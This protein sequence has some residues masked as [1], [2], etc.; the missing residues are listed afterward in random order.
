MRG[1]VKITRGRLLSELVLVGRVFSKKNSRQLGI[2]YMPG[3]GGKK[4][5]VPTSWPSK[6]YL[7]ALPVFVGQIG[8]QRAIE[9]KFYLPL[10]VEAC[11]YD[12]SETWLK[13][14][15]EGESLPPEPK[16]VDIDNRS[17]SLFDVM[18]AANH[19]VDDVIIMRLNIEK[20]PGLKLPGHD[21]F[22]AVVKVYEATGLEKI[23]GN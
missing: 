21:E 4:R 18:K 22:G 12:W 6:A 10:Y 7:A 14:F 19:I 15:L 9:D 20:Y 5:P 8:E 23:Y 17:N 1:S 3:R 13:R 2:K 11:V 16:G